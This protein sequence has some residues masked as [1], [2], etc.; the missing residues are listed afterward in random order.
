MS[1]REINQHR[2]QSHYAPYIK[3]LMAAGAGI[4]SLLV[5]KFNLNVDLGYIQFN[6]PWGIL[7]PLLISI[8]FGAKYGLISGFSGGAL[9]PLYLWPQEGYANLAVVLLLL[10]LYFLS[11]KIIR[12]YSIKPKYPLPLKITLIGLAAA[13]G[14]TIIYLVLYNPLLALNP[15]FW[16]SETINH[17]DISTLKAFT[18]KDVLNFVFMVITAE[19]LLKLPLIRKIFGTDSYYFMRKNNII[20]A[21][22]ILTAFFM[23]FTF[24]GL[25]YFLLHGIKNQSN[26]DS[27]AF[28]IMMATGVVVARILIRFIEHRLQAEQAL[29]VSEEKFRMISE[30]AYDLI[31]LHTIDGRIKYVSKSIE[32]FTGL[33]PEKVIGQHITSFLHPED[34]AGFKESQKQLLEKSS[35]QTIKQRI[36]H[37]NGDYIWIESNGKLL[38]IKDDPETYIQVLSRNINDRHKAEEALREN[39]ETLTSIF[40]HAPF[41]MILL[42]NEKKIV[43][44]NSNPLMPGDTQENFLGKTIGETFKCVEPSRNK[45]PCGKG[46]WCKTC[47]INRLFTEAYFHDRS[48]NKSEGEIIIMSDKGINKHT[49]LVSSSILYRSAKKYVL[50]T[51]DDITARK[52]MEVQLEKAKEKAEESDKLKSAFLANMSHEI[53]TPMNGIIGFARMLKERKNLIH[54]TDRYLDI[55]MENSKR[56]MVLVN[57]IL[58]ISGIESGRLKFLYKNIHLKNMLDDIYDF[59]G[60]TAK[61][62]SLKLRVSKPQ[63]GPDYIRTDDA[64]LRQ[65]LINLLNNALK[66][67]E[68][69]E[70]EFGYTIETDAIR[71]FVRDTGI[72]IP[73]SEKDNIFLRFRQVEQ[74]FTKVKGGTGLGLSISKKIVEHWGGEI[75]VESAPQKGSIFNFTIPLKESQ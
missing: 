68:K 40:N 45:K 36:K 3:L 37:V 5:S 2:L 74:D 41:T 10:G 48:Y 72:G 64:R 65:V 54:K 43:K 52:E 14:Y 44:I 67:T 24:I 71:F 17:L 18:V 73:E 22:S 75:W 4:L 66:F 32:K 70:I 11:S 35:I 1:N 55:I 27:I 42:D 38:Q 21:Y 47:I 7:L 8:A 53:R 57:D 63:N 29:S 23:W 20:F 56:L 25:D 12:S 19:L 46:D 59:I 31:A 62:K 15:P 33:P 69:G 61:E 39:E 28:F 34:L 26:Y 16:Q 50:L 13:F 51:I 58:D 30:N 60:P 9:Y 49:V 6:F